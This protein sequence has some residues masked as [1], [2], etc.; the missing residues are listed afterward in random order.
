[1]AKRRKKKAAP[2][3]KTAAARLTTDLDKIANYF[4]KHYEAIGVPKKY[5]RDFARRCDL[6]SDHIEKFAGYFDPSTI[7]E[8]KPG[9]HVYDSDEDYMMNNFTQ[10]EGEDLRHR[11]E[12]D[13]WGPWQ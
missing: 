13:A 5:A 2:I 1:M 7:G 10:I 11:Q 8:V 3:R 6:F 12:D 4:E 9:P